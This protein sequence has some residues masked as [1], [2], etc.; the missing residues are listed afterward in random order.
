MYTSY[1]FSLDQLMD[2][3]TKGLNYKSY[4]LLGHA[5]HDWHLS[6]RLRGSVKS[7]LCV[8]LSFIF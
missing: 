4:D 5:R 3:F 6:S 8:C 7:Y 1:S 2:I